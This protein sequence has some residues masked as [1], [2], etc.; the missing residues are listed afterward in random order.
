MPTVSEKS[1]IASEL[2]PELSSESQPQSQVREAATPKW[3]VPTVALLA[4][5][6][7]LLA[8]VCRA[9]VLHWI[10]EYTAPESYYAH[11]PLIPFLAGLML[12]HR[13]EALKQV[14]K[15]PCYGALALL[16]PALG[17]L[18]L[19]TKLEMP[20]VMSLG[21]LLTIWSCVWLVLGTAFVRA[22]AFPLGFLL[23]MAPLPGPLLSEG[24]YSIQ[25]ASTQLANR[26]LHLL[27][28]PTTLVGNVITLD[29]YQV[30]VDVPCSGFKLLLALV[31]CNAALAYLL[32]GP[33]GRRVA[34][35]LFSLPLSLAI[36]AVRLTLLCI[37]GECFGARAGGI[38]HDWDGLLTVGG[39]VVVLLLVARRMGCR[40][41]AGWPLF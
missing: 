10:S 15:R 31:T 16:G 36:N 8:S 9:T 14:V 26:L 12:W 25:Q 27:M 7:G 5:A 13:R 41:F 21:F 18:I 37:V 35:F 2:A 39:G 40:T 23:L 20:A 34:L 6:F 32:D 29:N 30:F 22:A 28:F 24:T 38:F 4:I 17:L 33:G 11:A 3:D 1:A 19:A